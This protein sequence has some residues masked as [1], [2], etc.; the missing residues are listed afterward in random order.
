MHIFILFTIMLI[1]AL[2]NNRNAILALFRS[3]IYMRICAPNLHTNTAYQY[4]QKMG[5]IVGG[6]GRLSR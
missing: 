5:S 1:L 6:E 4:Y 2:L 3:Y